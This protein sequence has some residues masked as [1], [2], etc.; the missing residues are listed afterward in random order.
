MSEYLVGSPLS[1]LDLLELELELE[2][3]LRLELLSDR[4]DREEERSSNS[5]SMSS[6]RGD[7][8]VQL[9]VAVLAVKG[10]KSNFE[11]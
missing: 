2:L 11:F 1:F 7:L 9:L 8:S 5:A 4:D 10:L 3:E 6:K